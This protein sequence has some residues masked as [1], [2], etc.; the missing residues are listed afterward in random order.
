MFGLAVTLLA[1]V[2]AIVIVLW[3]DSE[4]GQSRQ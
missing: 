1:I 4:D 3:D 2:C